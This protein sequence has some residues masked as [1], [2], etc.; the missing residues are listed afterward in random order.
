MQDTWSVLESASGRP[1]PGYLDIDIRN[2]RSYVEFSTP[3]HYIPRHRT[4]A[5]L[6]HFQPRFGKAYHVPMGCSLD[7]HVVGLGRGS[8]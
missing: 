1:L 8:H 4:D 7:D 5:H 6:G 2:L 3:R